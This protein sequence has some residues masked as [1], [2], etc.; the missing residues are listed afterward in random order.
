MIIMA[1]IIIRIGNDS[2]DFGVDDD[3]DDD[4]RQ[5][6]I[7]G[8]KYNQTSMVVFQARDSGRERK[9]RKRAGKREKE[10]A[11]GISRYS[12]RVVESDK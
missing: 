1:V 10:S 7:I 3:D 6:K 12:M 5:S 9:I 4:D 11:M 2:N 8:T